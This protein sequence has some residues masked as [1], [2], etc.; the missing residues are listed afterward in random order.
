MNYNIK[1]KLSALQGAFV[2]ELSG[3]TST[4][5]CL[6]IPIA[7]AGLFETSKGDVYLDLTAWE[8]R[9]QSPYGDT[10]F[11][12]RHLSR[13]EYE[14]TPEDARRNLPII[15]DLRPLVAKV[16]AGVQP[17][18]AAVQQ[19]VVITAKQADDLPF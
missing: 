5:R 6:V 12:K 1:V 8:R 13:E 18:Q 7:D 11:L 19:P 4:K 2:K 9:S 16:D 17:P 10:H 15:G 3:S 14:K